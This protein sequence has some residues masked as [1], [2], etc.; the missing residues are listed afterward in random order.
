MRR[1][2]GKRVSKFLYVS[3][4]FLLFFIIL[5]FILYS[6]YNKKLEDLSKSMLSSEDIIGLSSNNEISNN[7]GNNLQ[8][9]SSSLSQTIT[10]A[11]KQND[12]ENEIEEEKEEENIEEKEAETSAVLENKIIEKEKKAEEKVEEPKEEKKKLEFSYPVEG[13][14]AKDFSMETLVFSE[15][16]QEWT[17]HQGIDIVAD[18]TTVVKSAERGTVSA[19]K[20]DPRYGLTVVIEHEDGFKTIYSNLLSTE[21]IEEGEELQKGDS[22]ATIGNSAAFEIADEPHLHFEM[23]K[24]DAYVDPKIYLK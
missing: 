15:T 14:I 3:G 6:R 13:E 11:L 19:I 24:D 9:A 23:I 17:I 1:Q 12:D 8:E 20:N 10:E 5:F 4:G 22:I 18:R 16:L 21:F 7:L 2:R